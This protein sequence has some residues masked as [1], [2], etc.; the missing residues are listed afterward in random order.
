[1]VLLTFQHLNHPY[2]GGNIPFDGLA[3]GCHSVDAHAPLTIR[4]K[5][6]HGITYSSK[7][8]SAQVK[9]CIL[10]AGLNAD[11]ETTFEEPY[12]S[13]NH[14]EKLFKYLGADISVN[15]NSKY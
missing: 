15:N 12:V 8:A 5:K 4:G 14:T 7:L 9:S 13:R 6:L 1:M 2:F 11:G 10:L 3:N